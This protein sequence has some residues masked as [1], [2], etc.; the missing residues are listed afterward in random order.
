MRARVHVANREAS[1]LTLEC[2]SSQDVLEANVHYDAEAEAAWAFDSR[3]GTY[4]SFDDV[5]AVKAKRDYVI[6]HG[7]GGLMYWFTGADDSDNT[8]L[9]AMTG[10]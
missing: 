7:L 5:R 1:C 2:H 6:K 10:N 9:K 4:Y 3:R 8:L